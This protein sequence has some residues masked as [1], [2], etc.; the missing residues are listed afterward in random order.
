MPSPVLLVL[1]GLIF[2]AA[3]AAAPETVVGLPCE[4]C[5]AVHVGMPSQIASVARIAPAGE[6]GEA[7]QLSGHV[8]DADGKPAAGI[9]VYA[10][11]TDASGH[12]PRDPSLR[13][14]SAAPHGR[15]RGWAR[16]DEDGRYRVDSVRPGGYPGRSDPQHIHL[17][18]IEPGRCTYYIDDVNFA[19]DPRLQGRT[20]QAQGRG[21]DG[22]T[23]PQRDAQGTWQATRDIR[24]GA[25][26][27]GYAGCGA[28][29][30]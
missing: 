24:L 9:I 25:N 17:H 30:R 13:G 19:D 11:Q 21:G 15:L 3:Q 8:R 5:E 23:R 29:A 28:A 4:G 26:I 1:C 7:L 12:Y 10:Y 16:S 6:A 2:V 20:G 22:L 27:P 18:V 14:T